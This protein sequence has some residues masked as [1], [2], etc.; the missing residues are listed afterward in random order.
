MAGRS[1]GG[2]RRG[3]SDRSRS[4][5]S[6]SAGR[7][8]KGSGASGRA[9][10]GSRGGGGPKGA[11]PGRGGGARGGAPSGRAN[12][13][14]SERARQGAAARRAPRK[15]PGRT[16]APK[17]RGL[18]G[19]QVEGRQA[20]R[21]LLLAG[22]RKVHEVFLNA[23]MDRADI[24]GD[25][26]DLA[27]ELRVPITEV[28]RGRLDSISHTEA[29]QGVVARAAELP[30]TALHDLCEP[31]DGRPPFLL[32]VDGVTDPGNLGALL[33][34][35]ECAG[36]TGV[37]LPR[38]RAVHITPTVT[39][40]AAGA[41]EYLRMALVGGLPTAISDLRDAGVWVVGLDAGGEVSVHDLPVATD[42][43][44]LVLGAE[45]KGLSRLAAQRCDL[46]ASIPLHGHLSSLNVASAGA[47][48]CYEIARR[49]PPATV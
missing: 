16:T 35:A 27:D 13:P 18:G 43:V 26:V 10:G 24:V 40:A 4:S 34:I 38:H 33:R 32:A 41:V 14:G 1:P 6:G 30:H 17:E 5:G 2:S 36:V 11:G 15:D 25:I 3:G 46:V 45:G 23:E 21:E 44:C 31:V 8:G 29:P 19:T 12:P 28:S 42:A 37:V 20:V 47:V 22:R 9:T 39:K 48:A 49:R 7:G